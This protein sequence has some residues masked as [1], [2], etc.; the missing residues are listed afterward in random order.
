MICQFPWRINPLAEDFWTISLEELYKR[1]SGSVRHRS[2][3]FYMPSSERCCEANGYILNGG[4]TRARIIDIQLI[5]DAEGNC[6]YEEV[7]I[8]EFR[9]QRILEK[10]A[11]CTTHAILPEIFIPYKQYSLRYILFHVRE[12]FKQSVT[13]EAYCLDAGIDI[14]AFRLWLKWIRDH[15]TV[16]A[17]LGLTEKYQDNWRIMQQWVQKL[18]A[19]ILEWT[20]Q[21]LKKL[22]LGLFQEHPMPENT[23]YRN[24]E[25]SG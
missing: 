20:A 13:Q 7:V 19:D 3:R 21:A 5:Q 14:K 16:L 11:G 9:I 18:N 15:L 4:Y 17:G 24:Y 25:R 12:F 2:V 6:R 10:G 23:M 8:I 1:I 22:N